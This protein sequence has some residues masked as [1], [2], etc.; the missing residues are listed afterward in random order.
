MMTKKP[1]PKPEPVYE[2]WKREEPKLAYDYLKKSKKTVTYAPVH[3]YKPVPEPVVAEYVAPEPE[4]VDEAKE[5]VDDEYA[6]DVYD[7]DSYVEDEYVEPVEEPE[8]VEEPKEE[9]KYSIMDRALSYAHGNK[10]GA[11]PQG[12]KGSYSRA[13]LAG[14]GR[15]YQPQMYGSH[16]EA[17]QSYGG[18]AHQTPGYG[19]QPHGYGHQ[20]Q[21]YGHQPHG[22]G[23]PQGYG[24]QP[25]GY[26]AP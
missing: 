17:A 10:Y 20:P 15:T 22:Y 25:H 11:D 26:G 7:E 1:E 14:H 5:Y 23:A 13:H 18:Y 12:Y 4:Y 9:K 24:H 16:G 3:Q 6:E 19:H 2:G 8:Y 21:G